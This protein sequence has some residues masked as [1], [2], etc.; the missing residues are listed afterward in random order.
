MIR[1]TTATQVLYRALI[2]AWLA[3]CFLQI[4]HEYGPE[5]ILPHTYG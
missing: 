5:E 3:Q 1:Y 4:I 2:R